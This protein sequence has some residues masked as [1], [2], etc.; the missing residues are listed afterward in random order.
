MLTDKQKKEM[1]DYIGQ[2]A[3]HEDLLAAGYTDKQIA[4]AEKDDV[5]TDLMQGPHTDQGTLEPYTPS[6]RDNIRS[7]VKGLTEWFGADEVTA[8]KVATGIA[9]REVPT[10]GSL[11]MGIIDFTPL[12]A[13][14]GTQ[15]AVKSVKRAYNADS[16]TG[17]VLGAVDAATNIAGAIPGGSGAVKG[18][19]ALAKNLLKKYDPTVTGA[20]FSAPNLLAN[21]SD[22]VLG[23]FFPRYSKKA[24]KPIDE[25]LEKREQ[26]F[27]TAFGAGYRYDP[28]EDVWTDPEGNHVTHAEVGVV[29]ED[30]FKQTFFNESDEIFTVYD[31]PLY[32]LIDNIKY[33][34]EGV[35]GSQFLKKLNDNPTVRNSEWN[36]LGIEI[37]PAKR[38]TKEELE[39]LVT[40]SRHATFGTTTNAG[41]ESYQRQDD[42][43]DPEVSYHEYVVK[44]NPLNPSTPTFKPNAGRGHF[45]EDVLAHSRFSIRKD[46]KTGEEYLLAEELQSD[47]LQK[48]FKKPQKGA[49]AEFNS[50][51]EALDDYYSK[52]PDHF[53]TKAASK[54]V[55]HDYANLAWKRWGTGE[56]ISTEELSRFREIRDTLADL[57][58]EPARKWYVDTYKREPDNFE[59][60]DTVASDLNGFDD[61]IVYLGQTKL[62]GAS[63]I[64]APPVKK[65]SEAVRLL[66]DGLISEADQRGVSKIVIPPIEKIVEKRF[67]SP[68][69]VAK[70]LDPKSGFYDTYVTS[71]NKYLKELKDEFGDG[72]QI[73][74]KEMVY[75]SKNT[76][77]V[78]DLL[79]EHA[80]NFRYPDLYQVQDALISWAVEGQSISPY[81]S[82][83]IEFLDRKGFELDLILS[84]ASD[85]TSF[86]LAREIEKQIKLSAQSA[87][88]TGIEIDFSGV[89][90]QNYDLQRPRFAEG[91][92]V[93]QDPISGN[94][95]PP[96][97][98]A[99][100]VRDNV[101]AKLSEG[102]YVLPA[103]VVKYFGLDYIEKLIGKAKKGME[104]LHAG[105]RIGGQGPDD[106]PFSPEELQAHETEMSSEAAP[107]QMAEGGLVP[108]EWQITDD[109]TVDPITGLPLWMKKPAS[110]PAQIKQSFGM[111]GGSGQ[112]DY[113]APTGLAGSVD[114]WGPD[115]FLNYA[116]NKD[117]F[118]NRGLETAIG[119]VVPFGGLLTKARHN[120]LD[121]NVPSQLDA[122]IESGVDRQGNPLSALQ[123]ASLKEARDNLANGPSATG[124]GNTLKRSFDG[125]FHKGVSPVKTSGMAG[126]SGKSQSSTQS[127][128]SSSSKGNPNGN[129]SNMTKHFKNGGFVT[130]RKT[131]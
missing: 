62:E 19:K 41:Y 21:Q 31:T 79:L 75:K 37:D 11:G 28:W 89:K 56:F 123:I 17:M 102:E 110:K 72:V 6:Y 14:T 85:P 67:T 77:S 92:V 29:T 96:G 64:A 22:D 49:P 112:N 88:S 4:E 60:N 98:T 33:P 43:L 70:A 113:K 80:P 107:V 111:D 59:L 114:Q 82:D 127:I 126:P 3:N 129:D 74:Q 32:L 52:E 104:E 16:K 116:K 84:A 106:L 105:G 24:P 23:T 121:K 47:L 34:K 73:S 100:E 40:D 38:Y 42:L 122:M 39:K 9:G 117:S 78:D 87:P 109:N 131:P 54:E 20:F 50:I 125:L 7:N 5:P 65:T 94:T 8:D 63:P 44:H 53:F 2:G 68:T 10:D 103:D 26:E 69:E 57:S 58:R 76:Q 13:L 51:E 99:N 124:I 120:Y 71:V 118:V 86:D 119:A 36:N 25:L 15:E 18:T 12:G 115:D 130:R 30:P 48:G 46:A 55:I 1:L 91:G 45:G 35:K 101:D 27:D 95:I 83:F 108:S 66:M 81:A 128:K 90:N 97:S 93:E 61:N